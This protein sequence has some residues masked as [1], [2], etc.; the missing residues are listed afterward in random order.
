MHAP[1]RV[2]QYGDDALFRQLQGFLGTVG[3]PSG[4]VLHPHLPQ[5]DGFG[6]ADGAPH[7]RGGWQV[8]EH[9]ADSG[10]IQAQSNARGNVPCAANNNQHVFLSFVGYRSISIR[11]E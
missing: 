4:D 7:R 3:Q 1:L 11:A 2:G 8:G 10:P 5:A 6:E 9:Q